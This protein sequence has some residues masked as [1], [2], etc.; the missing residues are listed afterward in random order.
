MKRRILICDD[1]DGMLE[2]TTAILETSGFEPLRASSGEDALRK[3]L[4]EKPDAILLDILMPDKNGWETLVD[5]KDDPVTRGIPVV[6]LSVLAPWQG[7][8]MR[9]FFDGWV[10]KPI[11]P[12]ELVKALDRAIAGR[13][14]PRL[15]VVE[16]DPV[17][18]RML[19]ALF[20]SDGVEVILASTEAIAHAVLRVIVPDLVVLDLSL[21][22]GD[23]F[24]L[25]ESMRKD[26]ALARVPVVVYT[27]RDVDAAERERLSVGRTEICTKG[28][29]T[30]EELEKRVLA[31]LPV[32]GGSESVRA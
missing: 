4:Q 14:N 27:A 7:S 29:V 26:A 9:E 22:D 10:E 13:R 3:A 17:A 25:F 31:L 20:E 28:R 15:V 24:S 5:L 21:A 18:A 12:R 32:R 19:V 23:G 16:D 30:I 1:D 2:M 8:V 11:E 6:I